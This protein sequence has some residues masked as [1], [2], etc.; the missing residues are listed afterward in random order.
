MLEA[1][2]HCGA[3]RLEI[4]E[5][6]KSLTE[7]NCSICRRLGVQWAYYQQRQI[8][9]HCAD[10]ALTNYRWQDKRIEFCTC[11]TC[12]CTTHYVAVDKRADGHIAINGRAIDPAL[13]S[14]VPVRL[15]D[16]ADTFKYL[17]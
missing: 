8:T 15:F 11:K 13:I 4:E 7:C 12:G 1:S 10:D 9:I 5:K 3:V 6:P 14:D 2:C 17:D 16:G